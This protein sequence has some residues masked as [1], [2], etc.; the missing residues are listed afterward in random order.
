MNAADF[1]YLSEFIKRRSGIELTEG[2][3][4]LVENRLTPVARSYGM[5]GLCELVEALRTG[6][7]PKIQADV[8]DAMTTNESFFF[9]DSAPFDHFRNETLP[10]LLEKR[11]HQ[12]SFRIWC[13][14]A[15]SGQEPYS[16]AMI[17]KEEARQLAGWRYEIVGTDISNQI[18]S[19]AK[20][21]Q[22]TQFEVQRGLP[23]LLLTKYFT[24]ADDYW[25]ISPEIR[26]M[27][28]FKEFN[29]LDSPSVLGRF[30]VVFCRNVLIYF[31]QETK[32][33]ILQRICDL[34]PDDGLL[35]LGAAETT[36]GISTAFRLIPTKSGLYSPDRTKTAQ[37]PL[38]TTNTD[39]SMTCQS[40][41]T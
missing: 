1:K 27:V 38:A 13:A 37:E 16:I 11:A 10:M 19:K 12:K 21:G 2:K 23:V 29:L 25:Q 40:I 22:Y 5:K 26:S 31:D 35:A 24:K 34:M 18:L 36:L 17:L 20:Q 4:Y 3:Q 8:T 9:R 33:G 41:P 32:A 28:T 14:A 6:G 15:S 39:R 7:N 30:D